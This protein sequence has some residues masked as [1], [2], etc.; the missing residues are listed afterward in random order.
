MN[1][2]KQMKKKK[3][4]VMYFSLVTGGLLKVGLFAFL[5]MLSIYWV[6]KAF[7][8]FDIIYTTVDCRVLLNMLI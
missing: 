4:I 1:Q 5:K 6:S 8:R 3:M 7:K 2:K